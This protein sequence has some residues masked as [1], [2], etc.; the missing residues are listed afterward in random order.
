M[1]DPVYR[2]LAQHLD[3]I[4]NGYPATQSGIE[5][6]LLERLFTPDE[7]RLACVM[8]LESEP[9]AVIAAAPRPRSGRD[10]QGAQ[11]HGDEGPDW[12]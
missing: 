12:L 9:P 6:R 4:P 11:S 10:A 7:A 1:T 2:Q 8:R 3:A 5:L